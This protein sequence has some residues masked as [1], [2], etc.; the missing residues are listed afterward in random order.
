LGK[1]GLENVVVG[2]RGRINSGS[3]VKLVKVDV[4]RVGRSSQ[5]LT[6]LKCMDDGEFVGFGELVKRLREGGYESICSVGVEE[7][8]KWW[9]GKL[10][11]DGWVV[12]K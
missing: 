2:G 6:I 3:V 8:C 12:V 1:F 11:R 7:S 9:L 4:K 10:V 5:L